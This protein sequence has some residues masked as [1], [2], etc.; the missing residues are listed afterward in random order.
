MADEAERRATEEGQ[1]VLMELQ[2]RAEEAEA[3]ALRLEVAFEKGLPREAVSRL[4]G[5]TREQLETDA[6]AFKALMRR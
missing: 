3:R 6:E 2:A 4:Q 5:R 1:A